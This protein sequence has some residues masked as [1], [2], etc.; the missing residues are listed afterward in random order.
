MKKTLEISYRMAAVDPASPIALLLALYDTLV[1]N[2]YRAAAAIRAGDIDVRCAQLSHAY[3]V[4]GQLESWLDYAHDQRL[5]ESL[6][7]FYAHLR[8][9]MLKASIARDASV[10]DNLVPLVL[11][12]R[13]TW[14]QRE[15]GLDK[16]RQLPDEDG[17]RPVYRTSTASSTNAGVALSQTA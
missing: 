4:L 8:T 2:L 10:M 14:Q 1:G 6:A 9:Q 7:T 13:A 11:Q 15:E 16:H 17:A 5:S 3:L 12:I